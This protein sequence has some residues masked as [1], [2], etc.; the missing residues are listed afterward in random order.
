MKKFKTKTY[1]FKIPPRDHFKLLFQWFRKGDVELTLIVV[2]GEYKNLSGC[3]AIAPTKKQAVE[4]LYG[5]IH[6]LGMPKAAGIWLIPWYDFM[7][8]LDEN[9]KRPV[10]H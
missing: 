3:F 9:E 7:K 1:D 2:K 10:V 5:F 4:K 8:K 6:R